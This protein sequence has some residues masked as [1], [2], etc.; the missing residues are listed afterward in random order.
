MSSLV[1]VSGTDTTEANEMFYE[2]EKED[3]EMPKRD[4]KI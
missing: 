3:I 1:K 4:K 2:A